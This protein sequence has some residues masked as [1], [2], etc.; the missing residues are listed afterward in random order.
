[1]QE[2]VQRLESKLASAEEKC[3]QLQMEVNRLDMELTR[4][5]T[6]CAMLGFRDLSQSMGIG[7]CGKDEGHWC[8]FFSWTFSFMQLPVQWQGR[9]ELG[10]PA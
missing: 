6:D 9:Q 1:M 7:R 10:G 8:A 2:A 5:F 3:R 4:Y